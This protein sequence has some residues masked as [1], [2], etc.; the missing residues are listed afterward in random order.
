ME[1]TDSIIQPGWLS[2]EGSF[3]SSD[4]ALTL[5]EVCWHREEWN[6]PAALVIFHGFGDHSGRYVHF[7][8]HGE[9]CFD[10]VFSFD[11]RGHGRSEG[12]RGYAP[13]FDV[14]VEDGVKAL[15]RAEKAVTERFGRTELHL[16]AHSMGGLIALAMLMKNPDLPLSS[17]TLS[18]P[19]LGII[20]NLRMLRASAAMLLSRLFK[21]IRIPSVI[22]IS[23]LTHDKGVLQALIEDPLCHG[24][25]TPMLFISILKTLGRARRFNEELPY[26]ILFLAA[27]ED[28]IVNASRTV[29]FFKSISCREKKLITCQDAYH[30][31]FNEDGGP[32]TKEEAFRYLAEWI[33]A[34]KKTQDRLR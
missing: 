21:G 24:R 1:E 34:H 27:G 5:F 31:L 29:S 12:A 7:L 19:L 6:T 28:Y 20:P 2:K 3:R 17:V 4:D 22:D 18:S 25:M 32:F 10:A 13:S 33:N 14:L 11:H 8:S 9:G 30:E 23:L 16:L 26:P 15:R